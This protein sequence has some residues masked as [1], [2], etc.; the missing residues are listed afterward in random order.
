M[1]HTVGEHDHGASQ[2]VVGGVDFTAHQ[3]VESLVG[4]ADERREEKRT[5]RSE[6]ETNS[7][8]T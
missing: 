5:T 2:L 6:D 7:R 8:A 3:L 4:A 1:G